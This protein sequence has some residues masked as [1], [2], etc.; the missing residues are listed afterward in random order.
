MKKAMLCLL[1]LIIGLGIAGCGPT[2]APVGQNNTSPKTITIGV[3]PDVESIPFLL[4]EKNGYFKKEGVNV[5]LE[6]FTSAKDRDSALQSGQLDGVITDVLAVVFANEGGIGLKIISPTDGNI[7]LLAGKNSGIRSIQDLKGKSIGMSTN[8]I[9]EYS[10]DKMLEAGQLSPEEVKKVAI[11]PLPTRLEMVQGGKIDAA[12]LPE[13]LAGLAVKNGARILNST[14]RMGN[15]AGAIAFTA[16][17]LQQSPAEI[18]AVFRAYNDAVDYMSR[19]PVKNYIDY[20]IQAQ[21]FP[22]AVKDSLQVP[23]YRKAAAPDPQ[24]LKDVEKWMQAKSLIKG[25][26]EYKDLVDD[27]VLR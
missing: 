27:K 14:D 9:M 5:K 3:M 8:T 23:V 18:K 22:A 21:G 13:P 16:Q 20:I 6:H 26:Y 10:A 1:F 15:K 4:A 11:P 12:I 2:K 7:E 19:E 25:N 24:I 17:S